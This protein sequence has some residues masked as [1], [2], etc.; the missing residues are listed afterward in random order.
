MP[1]QLAMPCRW[2]PDFHDITSAGPRPAAHRGPVPVGA[3]GS[4]LASVGDG[5]EVVELAGIGRWWMVQDP[6][7]GA[8]VPTAFWSS[9][10]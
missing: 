6:A 4:R 1:S 3:D 7:L 2:G 8:S 9:L 10:P 5:F